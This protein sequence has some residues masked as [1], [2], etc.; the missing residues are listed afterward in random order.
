MPK[1]AR[2]LTV[3]EVKKLPLGTHAVGG[4]RGL[5]LRKTTNQ[6]IYILRYS[7]TDG[8]HDLSI[9]QSSEI[10][11]AEAR[12]VARKTLADIEQGVDPIA[13]RKEQRAAK[14]AE[15]K[16]RRHTFQTVAEE[17]LANRAANDYWRNNKRGEAQARGR[18]QRHAYPKIGSIPINE[19]SETDVYSV[20]APLWQDRHSTALKVKTLLSSICKRAMA[21]GLR[22]AATNPAEWN[23]PLSVL[24]ESAKHGVQP[25]ENF[26][27]CDFQEIPR[28]FAELQQFES[29]TAR[30]IAFAILTASRSQAV[31][32]AKW[33]D[34]NMDD[35]VW[36]VPIEDDKVKNPR[37]DRR[38]FL[39]KAARTLLK[40]TPRYADSSYIFP[41]QRGQGYLTDMSV[42][43]FIRRLHKKRLTE[44]QVGWI[45]PKKSKQQGR[46]CIITF[47][48]TA[49][50]S[51]YT[52]ARDDVLGNLQRFNESAIDRCLLHLPRDRYS[53]AYDRALLEKERRQIME[54]WGDYCTSA[55]KGT[56][57]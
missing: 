26:A 13:L 45:D 50:S 37:I 23:G 55:C 35:G 4:V 2:E 18:L 39:S 56:S 42:N 15:R 7:S 22:K 53:G 14:Q 49:R 20:L 51:F 8:R 30:L 54:A 12:T 34:I 41:S 40:A 28:L 29:T 3:L 1:K 31:R 36:T 46:P 10:S 17:W 43:M 57:K 44:D 16:I 52:W 11:L 33:A 38:V 48:G 32:R 27:A 19:L 5:Y 9:G 25:K 47:H 21:L 6:S 24:L